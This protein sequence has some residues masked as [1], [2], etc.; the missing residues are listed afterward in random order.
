MEII[1]HVR[2]FLNLSAKNCLEIM[3]FQIRS[4]FNFKLFQYVQVL[5]DNFNIMLEREQ[6]QERVST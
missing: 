1:C 6:D 3:N 2:N 5:V 4:S